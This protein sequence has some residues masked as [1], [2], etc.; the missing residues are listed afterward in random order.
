MTTDVRTLLHDSAE[1][2]RHEPDIARALRSARTHRRRQRGVGGLVA[3]VVIALVVGL[4]ARGGIGGGDPQV[5][6]GLR[7]GGSEIPDGW[8]TLH[9]EPGIEISAP[10]EWATIP[11][12]GVSS[13]L[14]SISIGSPAFDAADPA[15]CAPAIASGGKWLTVAELSPETAAAVD[16]RAQ[17]LPNAPVPR[18]VDRPTDFLGNPPPLVTSGC[19]STDTST[20]LR[21][22]LFVDAGRYFTAQLMTRPAD[23]ESVMLGEQVLNTLRVEPLETPT[24]TVPTT[25]VPVTTTPK[26]LPPGPTITTVPPFVGTTDDERMIAQ[27]FIVW[28][29][30]QS[31]A[32]L[33]ASVADPDAVR[34]PSHE[35]WGQHTPEDLAQYEGL[36]ESVTVVDSDH[37]QVVYTILHAGQVAFP[38]RLGGA[39]RVNGEWKVTTETVCGMLAIGGITCPAA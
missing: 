34:A 39:V 19:A 18:M 35:G 16:G 2:P 9:V 38:R 8:Q 28:M 22:W 33:D 5:A 26:I 1:A 11:L 36:V 13:G 10:P 20:E 17:D 30:D 25:T 31:D 14:P 37:A 7:Q 27:M 4:V 32:G 3:V 24:T 6:V 23:T 12:G 21:V 29:D 15:A